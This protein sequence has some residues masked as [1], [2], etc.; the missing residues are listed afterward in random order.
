MPENIGK[1]PAIVKAKCPRCRQGDMFEYTA[2]HLSKFH[3]MHEKCPCCGLKFELEP[4]FF[5]GAMYVNYAFTIALIA[6][7]SIALHVFDLYSLRNFIISILVTVFLLIPL[8]FRYSRVLF[9]HI[10]GAVDYQPGKE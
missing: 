6:A 4:G 3:K 5:V 10:F 9:L 1:L 8:L 7:V 2:Y